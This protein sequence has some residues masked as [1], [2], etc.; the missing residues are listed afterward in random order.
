MCKPVAQLTISIK[1][2]ALHTIVCAVLYTPGGAVGWFTPAS[3][4]TRE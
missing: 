4:R 3:V 2:Y 1:Y